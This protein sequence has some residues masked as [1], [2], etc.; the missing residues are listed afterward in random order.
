MFPNKYSVYLHDTPNKELFTQDERDLSSGCIRLE[1]PFKLLE[2][3]LRKNNKWDLKKVNTILETN[4][5]TAI[6]LENKLPIH[7]VYLTAWV[8]NENRLQIR[9]DIYGRD[10]R[11]ISAFF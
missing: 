2:Y 9:N 6:I 1:E 3:I 7:I 8:D 10:A 11:L 5:E 4:K